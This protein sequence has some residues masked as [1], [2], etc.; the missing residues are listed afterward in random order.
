M[1]GLDQKTY[2]CL[3]D[4]PGEVAF[5]VA[6]SGADSDGVQTRKYLSDLR[7]AGSGFL[8]FE[9]ASDHL[10]CQGVAD[11]LPLP[12]GREDT[13]GLDVNWSGDQTKMEIP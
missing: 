5:T 3:K 13:I 12:L 11:S 1:K 4:W 9:T 8:D 2:E 10:I 6:K 7:D